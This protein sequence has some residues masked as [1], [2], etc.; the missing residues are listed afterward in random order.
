MSRDALWDCAEP[1]SFTPS[2]PSVPLGERSSVQQPRAR[3]QDP[4][5]CIISYCLGH[6]LRFRSAC[7][8]LWAPAAGTAALRAPPPWC[9]HAALRA[10]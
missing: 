8:L 5:M 9:T 7:C 3:N 10:L 1:S 2:F 4:K 6:M